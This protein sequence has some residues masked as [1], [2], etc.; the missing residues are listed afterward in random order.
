MRITV[1]RYTFLSTPKEVFL[2]FFSFQRFLFFKAGFLPLLFRRRPRRRMPFDQKT[3]GTTPFPLLEFH[4]LSSYR[5]SWARS[6][7]PRLPSPTPFSGRGY[8]GPPFFVNLQVGSLSPPR[9]A[10]TPSGFCSFPVS[11]IRVGC[12]RTQIYG[13]SVDFLSF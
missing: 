11:W 3:G 2:F 10:V 13:P 1:C 9:L 6:C 4:V 12:L 8:L 7:Q 5:F